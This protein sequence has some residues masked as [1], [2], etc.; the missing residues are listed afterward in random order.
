MDAAARIQARIA[1]RA[2]NPPADQGDSYDPADHT[3]DNVKLHVEKHPDEL[4]A[5]LQAETAGKNRSTLVD[6]LEAQSG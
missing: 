6:W 2:A 3:V 4:E 5:V 1:E